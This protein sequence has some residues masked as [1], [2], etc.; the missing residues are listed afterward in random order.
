VSFNRLGDILGKLRQRYPALSKRMKEAEALTRWEQAVGPA[1]AKHS[2]AVRVQDGV[3]WVEVDHPIWKSELHHRK[4]QILEILNRG[5]TEALSD[6][7][8]VEPRRGGR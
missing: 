6:L 1:I 8:L 2:R 4:R 7:L 5:A 3:L